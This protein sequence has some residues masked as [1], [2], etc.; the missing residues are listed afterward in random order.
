MKWDQITIGKRIGIGFGCVITLLLLLGGLSFTGVGSIVENASEVIDGKTL[1]GILA[2]KEV[3]HLNWAGA[4]NKLITDETVHTLAVQTDHTQCAFGKWLYGKG[5]EEAEQLVP[6]LRPLLKEIE[7]PH[8]HLHSSAVAIQ[9]EYAIADPQLPEFIAR[10]EID[11]FNWTAVIET[12]LLNNKKEIKVQ[13][14]HTKCSFGKWLY[15]DQARKSALLNMELG[16]LLE[17]I[18]HP[19]KQLHATAIKM[20]NEYKPTHP[21]LLNMLRE[22]LD[23]HRQ[24]AAKVASAIL[25]KHG[26]L[27]IQMDPTKCSFG[28]WLGSDEVDVLIQE[29]DEFKKVF[30]Q[31]MVP[32]SQLHKSADI[33]DSA[34]RKGEFAKAA[35]AYKKQVRPKLD[36]VVG[37]INKAIDLESKLSI[38]KNTAIHIFEFETVPQLSATRKVL[39]QI[40]KQADRLLVGYQKSADIYA[41]QTAPSLLT[42]QELLGK[43]R[44]IAQ[45]NILTDKAMLDAAKGTKRNVAMVSMI[46]LIAG[47][48]L[49]FLIAIGI[50]RTLSSVTTN[51]DEGANQVASASGQISSTS[52][53]LAEGASQQAASL[54]QTSSSLEEMSS[55]TKQNTNNAS[56]AELLGKE[57][58]VAV[59]D[60][61]TS[62]NELIRSMD[63]ISKAS[64]ETS[65]IV[66]TIDEIAFQTNLLALNAAVEAARAGEAGAGF[67]VVADEV[68]NLAMRAASAAKDTSEL[69][70]GTTGKVV[71]GVNLVEKTST[72][73]QQVQENTIKVRDLIG[74]ITAASKEQL[75]GIEQITLAVSEMDNVTQQNAANAEESA[76][77]SEE[78]NAQASQM[79]VMVD[80]LVKIVG[81]KT[82]KQPIDYEQTHSSVK[83]MPSQDGFMQERSIAPSH[84]KVISKSQQEIRPEQVIPFDD[85]DDFKDF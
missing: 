67:A 60:S 45:K 22:K 24:W 83:A 71:H 4:V 42:V 25:E 27:T 49:A 13:T 72:A 40:A 70:E 68:R 58:N 20:M 50:I 7:K 35:A 69:I 12:A 3:D 5:R 6:D 79:K 44:K 84:Q 18:K 32:H 56:N 46:A 11:H 74:E 54:E 15:G 82:D 19:H 26:S 85:E 30:D 65:K 47:V 33:V 21:G 37:L 80:D 8:Q 59:E 9:K 52:Q 14:D 57:S 41:S 81:A 53:S 38:A 64:E 23:D 48:G 61:M 75:D 1:D 34:L 2:Q 39:Q 51:L 78:M 28:K 17:E 31:I 10:K 29:S 66:K 76:S 77:A 73:F 62:M 55:M 63:D 36:Q 43:L 16:Q